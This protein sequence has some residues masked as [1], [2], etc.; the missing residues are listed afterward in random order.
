MLNTEGWHPAVQEFT[1]MFEYSH[2]PAGLP[3]EASSIFHRAA[4]ELLALLPDGPQLTRALQHL[5]EAKNEA[6]FLA[7]RTHKAHQADAL[8]NDGRLNPIRPNHFTHD[9]LGDPATC[10]GDHNHPTADR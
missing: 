7:V 4:D 9:S 2:L 6:V 8:Y 5:W 1:D 3:R 10:T